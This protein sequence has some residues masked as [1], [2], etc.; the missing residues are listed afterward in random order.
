MS[1]N[2]YLFVLSFIISLLVA[3]TIVVTMIAFPVPAVPDAPLAPHPSTL[4]ES[5]RMGF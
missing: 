2:M 5:T 4:P 3:M 1:S